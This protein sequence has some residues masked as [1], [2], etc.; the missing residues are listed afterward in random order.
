MTMLLLVDEYLSV[1]IR[2]GRKI[3]IL[4]F[5][6]KAYNEVHVRVTAET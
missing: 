4:I 2:R 5:K 6:C 1:K 3:L